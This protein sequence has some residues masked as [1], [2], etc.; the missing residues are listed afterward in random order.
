MGNDNNETSFLIKEKTLSKKLKLLIDN[1]KL[2]KQDAFLVPRADM[3]S[4]E[5]VPHNEERLK[6][7][8]NFSGSAGYAVISANSYVKSVIFSDG[9]Y[10][11]Q[12]KREVDPKNFDCLN[13]GFKEVCFFLNENKKKLKNIAIDPWLLTLKQYEL[14]KSLLKGSKIR[15]ELVDK[16]LIDEIWVKKKFVLNDKIFEIPYQIS[17][18][19]TSSKINRLKKIIKNNN[20]D[21]YILF[22]PPG[23]SWLLNIRGTDLRYT[24]VIRSFCVIS[25]TGEVLIF[26]KNHTLK[27]FFSKN[28]QIKI[29][30]LDDFYNLFL[31]FNN[32][33]F[34]I[35]PNFLPLKIYD[36]LKEND[37][38]YQIINCPVDKFKAIKN[39]VELSGFK[40][41]H[42]KDGL[43]ILKF[44]LW[45]EKNVN[46]NKLTEICLSRKL[47]DIRSLDKT[48]ICESFATI[49]AFADNGA[50]IHYKAN[51]S[52]NKKIDESSLYLIDT[53]AHYLD[54]TTDITRTLLVGEVKSQ[55]LDDYTLVLKGHIAISSASF[56][57]GTKGRELDTLGRVALWSD[58]KDYAHGTGHGVG[59]VLSVHEGPI[60][61]SKI[62][63]CFIKAGMV[64]SNEP[65]YYKKG[66]YGIRIENLE[67]VKEKAN[68][69]FLCFENLTRVPLELNLI[70]KKML[71]SFEINW[72][73][74]YHKK[75]YQDLSK[76]IDKNDKDLLLFLK[77][78]TI[79]I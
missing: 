57:V 53:G 35:D 17:G 21:F 49:S 31:N 78:K 11:L 39:P 43:A 67:V 36:I 74:N 55:M 59:H 27:K 22:N 48:F 52:S 29:Y 63:E 7:I 30:K 1:M 46:S 24:P 33:K 72:I 70:N 2:K 58:G 68:K 15:F 6:Y 54:G 8:S 50:I 69:N 42:L 14:L 34:L 44:L 45:F 79:A 73:N 16:N 66:E 32:K 26:T 25:K 23:F 61:I 76:L 9:R 56:P 47:F 77:R 12:L 51:I 5:E 71:S 60:S 62:S 3:Y 38:S 65:G 37:L 20:C 18:E 10:E 40:N 41:A 64:I 75:V 13:G 4:A 28:K 19:P